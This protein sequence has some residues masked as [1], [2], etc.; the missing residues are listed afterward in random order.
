MRRRRVVR[1][2]LVVAVALLVLVAIAPMLAG[3]GPV[4]R[5]VEGKLEEALG[6]PVA[7]AELE[8]GWAK[9]V[10]LRGLSVAN[11]GAEFGDDALLE[12]ASVDVPDPLTQ[13][14]FGGGPTRIVIDGLVVRVEEQAGGRTNVDDLIER[15]VAPR[16]PPPPEV[17][18]APPLQ[19]ELRR[20]S[21]RFRRVPY[22]APPRRVD[23]FVEDAILRD[24]DEGAL[25]LGVERL[26]LT[27]AGGLRRQEV[28]FAGGVSVNGKGGHV[29]GS[30][31][32][33]GGEFAGE[34]KAD[35]LDLE[36]L[37][38]FLP[39]QLKGKLNLE[40]GGDVAN[41]F[42]VAVR[43]ADFHLAGEKL[44]TV[45][46]EWVDLRA[47]VRRAD[48]GVV[49][50]TLSVKTASGEL[51]LDAGG[52]W[53]LAEGAP[54]HLRT[55]LPSRLLFV[56]TG[57]EPWRTVVHLDVE[58]TGTLDELDVAGKLSMPEMTFLAPELVELRKG[59]ADLDFD[60]GLHGQRLEIRRFLLE[61]LR[62]DANLSGTV[63]LA[64]PPAV[65]LAGKADVNLALVHHML[66]PFLDLPADAA[67]RG[68]LRTSD[69]LVRLDERR[70]AVVR[71]DAV[72]HGL[73]VEGVF[74]Q[75]L[76]REHAELHVDA[77]LNDDGNVLEVRRCQL[78]DLHAVARVVGLNEEKLRHAEGEVRGSL[79]LA[80]MPLQVAGVEEIDTLTGTLAV[81]LK[82]RTH[83]GCVKVT[84]SASIDR[85]LVESNGLV[86][87]SRS[88]SFAGS[89]ECDGEGRWA[90]SGDA[91]LEGL[92]VAGDFGEVGATLTVECGAR[93][94]GATKRA[95]AKATL[96]AVHGVGGFGEFRR[97]RIDLEGWI[98]EVEGKLSGDAAVRGEIFTIVAQL[99]D[100]DRADLTV[101]IENLERLN[102]TLPADLE[103]DGPL[104]FEANL[105]REEGG[106]TFGG[107]ARSG[108][109]T[110]RWQ[111]KGL[112]REPVA[113][114]FKG[115]E[116]EGGWTIEVP[117]L[118][119]ERSQASVQLRN[120]Y[121]APD[122]S[123]AAEVR[124]DLALDLLAAIVPELAP[125]ELQG[126][127]ETTAVVKH[128]REWSIDLDARA[129]DLSAKTASGKRTP[130]YESRLQAEVGLGAG[131]LVLDPVGL[132][133]GKAE[134]GGTGRLG[135]DVFELTLEGS[136]PVDG[137]SPFAP[138]RGEGDFRI[139]GLS[140]RLAKDGPVQLE[141][142][143][144]AADLQFQELDLL[145]P[146]IVFKVDGRRDSAGVR[147]LK[148]DI[149]ITAVQGHVDTVTAH[150]FVFHEQGH[151][152]LLFDGGGDYWANVVAK[153]KVLIVDQVKWNRVTLK[154][155][156]RVPDPL[157]ER[158]IRDHLTGDLAFEHWQLGPLPFTDA[159]CK[160]RFQDDFVAL[161]GIQAKYSQGDVTGD[162]KLWPRG[163]DVKWWTH[164]EGRDIQL[165]EDLG[166]PLSFLVP[167]LR[168]NREDKQGRLKGMIDTEFV[169]RCEGTTNQLLQETMNGY[170]SL[171]FENIEVQN[172][173]LIPLLG[174]RLDKLVLNKPYRFK[175]LHL[176]FKL[177]DG[178][179]KPK[180][181][182][183]NGQPFNIDIWGQADLRGTLDFIIATPT[184]ILPM[185]VSG[186]FDN[187]SVKPA[188]GARLRG[189]K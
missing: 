116:K 146:R 10:A 16:P 108:E 45:T 124:L 5:Y 175:D 174:L 105:R 154:L 68:W 85:L 180:R 107:G 156:G 71:A 161:N 103:L 120:G 125:Y 173:V 49:V 78:G 9:G 90:T 48:E 114:T 69:L 57:E 19:L 44:A 143:L 35:G 63:S 162:A 37:A 110:V 153:Q 40:V 152:E 129:K 91:R 150:E 104:R 182:K 3:I 54:F 81:D 163:T 96:E 171:D 147:D 2:L 123:F 138:I 11:R 94:E 149:R 126:A 131:E 89:A 148:T 28:S 99:Q 135:A 80:A 92:S 185:R 170:G 46:E 72:V 127:L 188:P 158:F 15:L 47:A 50:E 167:I 133:I 23:P 76:R 178:I 31:E 160:V 184:T 79:E 55:S 20:C 113:L 8:A 4:R 75:A 157:G 172:S 189:D 77:V 6:R 139:Q 117:S 166:D 137:M 83:K 65:D 70:N 21:F 66:E 32:I 64:D 111:D 51:E 106:W 97:D 12:I 187:P 151:G 144:T 13:L 53:P 155:G 43:I 101:A 7:L 164:L 128:D 181:F 26:D 169:L 141:G 87:R 33:A 95:E 179:L 134:F 159:T 52:R 25:R 130:T 145:R 59:R 22:R 27:V 60:V 67:I 30:V 118:E 168:V 42:D 18:P 61:G 132:Q 93:D 62:L 14:V 109:L 88:A 73:L 24:A 41:G 29:E 17:E 121:L 165:S 140:V 115:R 122:G 142:I 119:A 58:G 34:V 82:A 183:L 56:P 36:L 39:F 1:V 86:G 98:G 38:P 100:S 74:E 186:P 112:D 84:G 102:L 176:D 136:G 177:T